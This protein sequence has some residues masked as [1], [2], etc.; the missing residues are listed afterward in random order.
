MNVNLPK[1]STPRYWA[2][3]MNKKNVPSREMKFV[4]RRTR[5]FLAKTR[6]E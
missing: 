5:K 2:K 1:S 3:K 4:T 6:A